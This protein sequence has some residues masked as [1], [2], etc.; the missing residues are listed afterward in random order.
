MN[1]HQQQREYHYTSSDDSSITEKTTSRIESL[2]FT[3]SSSYV[4]WDPISIPLQQQLRFNRKSSSTRITCPIKIDIHSIP[5]MRPF[6][7]SSNQFEV[8]LNEKEYE[9]I[10]D[11]VT[12]LILAF[13]DSRHLIQ[14]KRE[15]SD[16]TIVEPNECK[17]ISNDSDNHSTRS[18]CRRHFLNRNSFTASDAATAMI[19][20]ESAAVVS[21]S[22]SND[23]AVNNMHTQPLRRRKSLFRPSLIKSTDFNLNHQDHL[24]TKEQQFQNRNIITIVGMEILISKHTTDQTLECSL[25]ENCSC[26]SSLSSQ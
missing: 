23:V 8:P 26:M 13:T 15:A 21:R 6:R 19:A 25:E 11:N 1:H 2:K 3:S 17:S 12:D 18:R 22:S 5:P 16:T 20:A 9:L 24:E 4:R 10:D 14:L 7:R